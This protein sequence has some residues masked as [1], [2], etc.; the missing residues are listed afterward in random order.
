MITHSITLDVKKRISQ[1]PPQ[2]VC[3]QG[4][5]STQKISASIVNDGVAYTSSCSSVRLDIL[6]ADNTW[7]EV[8]AS[9]SGSTVTCTLPSAALNSH[10]LCKLAHFV[11]FTGNTVVESTEGFELRILPAVT[12]KD[13]EGKSENYENIFADLYEKWQKLETKAEKNETTRETE[14]TAL[15]TEVKTEVKNTI[16]EI[17]DVYLPRD[18]AAD[19][20]L[21]Q[22]D[23]SNTYLTKT[24]ASNTYATKT[25]VNEIWKKIYPVGAVYISYVSTSPATLFGGTWVQITGRF[26]R[27]A[28]DV[29]TGGADTVTLTTE[30]IPSHTHVTQI[31]NQNNQNFTPSLSAFGYFKASVMSWASS[32]I[33]VAGGAG[34]DPAGVTQATGGG[35]A[36]N[37]MPAYQ[38]LYAW[39]RT[40]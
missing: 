34:G 14:W 21:T 19:T 36:H 17:D 40:A 16:E 26:L 39:R 7:A 2:V 12:P 10:G 15:K 37:N 22:T 30:Q 9:K 27:M 32:K 24:N 13:D 6:H 1:I 5:N 38:D 23:A 29:N 35:K 3:R 11:F 28:N 25:T 18:E 20:Y 8:A 33:K 4:E 31:Y